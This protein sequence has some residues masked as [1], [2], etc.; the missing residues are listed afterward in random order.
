MCW[1]LGFQG[2]ERGILVK[3]R[4]AYPVAELLMC[5]GELLCWWIRSRIGGFELDG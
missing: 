2:G 5:G 1:V 4:E 3:M